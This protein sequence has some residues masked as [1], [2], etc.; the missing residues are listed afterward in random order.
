MVDLRLEL[1]AGWGSVPAEAHDEF[2]R[3][4]IGLAREHPCKQK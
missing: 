3:V 1:A 4:N 2:D